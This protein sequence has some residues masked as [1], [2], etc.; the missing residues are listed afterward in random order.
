MAAATAAIT[1]KFVGRSASDPPA[2]SAT[3]AVTSANHCSGNTHNGLGCQGQEVIAG[4]EDHQHKF[5]IWVGLNCKLVGGISKS[6]TCHDLISSIVPS[7]QDPSKYVLVEK[8]K[9]VRKVNAHQIWSFHNHEM[10]KLQTSFTT[11][12]QNKG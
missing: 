7:S 9:K 5:P 1:E 8:W 2:A 10:W 3:A 11:R 6:T 4:A 12:K